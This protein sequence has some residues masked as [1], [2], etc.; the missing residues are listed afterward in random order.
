MQVFNADRLFEYQWPQDGGEWYLLQEQ[1]SEYLGV[2]SF[3]RKY[4]GV[5]RNFHSLLFHFYT[6]KMLIIQLFLYGLNL[7]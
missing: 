5:C 6:I 4:P 7:S 1:V 3:K 2:L